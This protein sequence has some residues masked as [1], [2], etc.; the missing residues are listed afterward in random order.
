MTQYVCVRVCVFANTHIWSYPV[1]PLVKTH[2]QSREGRNFCPYALETIH[3]PTCTHTHTHTILI[4]NN[5]HVC[6]HKNYFNSNGFVGR[7]VPTGDRSSVCV[8]VFCGE[9]RKPTKHRLFFLFGARTWAETGSTLFYLLVY[10]AHFF[11]VWCVCV[12]LK[13]YAIYGNERRRAFGKFTLHTH[14]KTYTYYRPSEV[15]A[16]GFRVVS[17]FRAMWGTI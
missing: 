11:F 12:R 6:E 7:A 10:V 3:P 5:E 15:N 16:R 8:C 17:L 2:V 13:P 9:C 4:W 14:T 1:C